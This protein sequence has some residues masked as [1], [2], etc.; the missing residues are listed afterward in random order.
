MN[1]DSRRRR[2]LIGW[3]AVGA[4]LRGLLIWFPRTFDPD[5]TTY[6][7]LGTNLLRHGVFGLRQGG[8]IAPSLVRL[9]G[10]PVFLALF[11][12]H[13]RLALVAQAGIDLYGCWLLY[14]FAARNISERAG[15]IVLAL[16]T[17]CIFTAAYAASGLAESLSIFAVSLGIYSFGE[18][19]RSGADELRS[20]AA[21]L[22]KIAPLAAAS[23]IA[24]LLR[25]DGLLLPAAMVVGMAWYGRK[26]RR[27]TAMATC[28]LVGLALLPLV[29]WTLRNWRAFHVVQPL[30]PEYANNPG[31]TVDYG[32]IRWFRTWAA[33]FSST[34]NIYWNLDGDVFDIGDLPSRA[35]DSA[36]QYDET[37][38]LFDEYNKH[39][40]MTRDLDAKFGRLAEERIA[41]HPLRYYLWLP[42]LR[43][44]DMWLRPRTEAFDLDVFWWRWGGHPWQS[45]AAIAL[46]L[47]N[48]AYL[49]A[50]L[51][52][53][54][55]RR[56]PWLVFLGSYVV[57]RCVLL[58]MMPAPEARYTLEAYPIVIV[59]A[60]AGLA[61]LGAR[62][63]GN[64]LG[65]GAHEGSAALPSS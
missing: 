24:V 61:M 29:P 26:Q 28:M 44:A 21:L 47:L 22:R 15:E 58:A 60:G 35:F 33:E 16:A 27:R 14:L 53:A 23:A 40:L 13:F 30:A 37:S 51:A 54:A 49:L 55:L 38:R 20:F 43:V 64:R 63:S 42:M 6:L 62:R 19:Q 7:E 59:C 34:G 10:Y 18:L 2:R 12:S 39:Q 3:L 36:A 45:V 5:T 25:P 9:P 48:L 52:G 57:L 50:A 56:V 41:A 46:G 32:F 4:V 8:L 65:D 11:G 17:L 31:E 1:G